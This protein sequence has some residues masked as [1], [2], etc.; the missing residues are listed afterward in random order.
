MAAAVN[1]DI[2]AAVSKSD[3]GTI[4]LRSRG[5]PDEDVVSLASLEPDAREFGKSSAMIRGVASAFRDRGGGF[6]AF[7]AYT[8]SD[9]LKGS[10]LSSSAAFEVCIAA[11]VNW[12]YNEG[13]FDPVTLGIIGQHAENKFFGKPSG[14]MDQTTCAVG[15]AISIDFENPSSPVVASVPLDLASRGISLV[16]TDTKGDHS[17]LTEEYAAIR[18]EMESVAG[19]FGKRC[20]REVDYGEFKALIAE[21]R[22]ETGDRAVVRAIHFF[23]ECRRVRE[24]IASAERGD[25]SRWLELMVECGHSSFE[26]NQNAYAIKSPQRQGISVGLAVSGGILRGRGAWRLQGGGFAGTIQAFVPKELLGEYNSALCGIF[27]EGACHVL[28]VRP[29]G[30]VK[31]G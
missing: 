17:N 16:V 8:A 9:V 5:F 29:A 20:L 4:R 11:I 22:R 1:L 28:R 24:A 19:F 31:V 30:G 18:S 25:I 23:E 2:I 3:T 7:D 27:G 15:G 13:R 14:L 12:E 26:F 10:G 21:V 6:G